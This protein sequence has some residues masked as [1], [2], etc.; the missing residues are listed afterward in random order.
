MRTQLRPH[1]VFCELSQRHD[2]RFNRMGKIMMMEIKPP[3]TVISSVDPISDR[4]SCW[5]ARV[6]CMK[7]VLAAKFIRAYEGVE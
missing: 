4:S 7:K 2:F 3:M 1:F 6:I 5:G